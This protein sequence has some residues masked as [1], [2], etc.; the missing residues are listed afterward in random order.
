MKKLLFGLLFLT[1]SLFATA[2]LQRAASSRNPF[3]EK[4]SKVEDADWESCATV[5]NPIRVKEIL[6]SGW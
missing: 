5:L 6:S 4:Y 2:R 3:D 1:A